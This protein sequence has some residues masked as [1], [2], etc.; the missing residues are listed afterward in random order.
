[1]KYLLTILLLLTSSVANAHFVWLEKEG[2]KS[3]KV[4]FGYWHR[5]LREKADKLEP[6]ISS[7]I[8]LTDKEQAIDVQLLENSLQANINTSGDVRFLQDSRP[9]RESKRTGKIS[10][11]YFY[12]KL[13]RAETKAAMDFE[14]VPTTSGGNQFTILLNGK[15][16]EKAKVTVY[17]PPKWQQELSSDKEGKVTINTPWSGTYIIRTSHKIEAEEGEATLENPMLSYAFTGT[18][19]VKNGIKWEGK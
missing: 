10:K 13:G 2:A 11:T 4:Y 8:F 17:G 15:P 12:A 16:I 19:H 5:D 7:K 18:I 3:V 1:M 9:A 14:M 6:F